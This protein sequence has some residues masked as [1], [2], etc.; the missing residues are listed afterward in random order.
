MMRLL[1][2]LF[3]VEKCGRCCCNSCWLF[4][5]YKKQ[6]N[7]KLRLWFTRKIAVFGCHVQSS[8]SCSLRGFEMLAGR[9]RE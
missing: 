2:Q 7:S 6:R 1:S 9:E 3:A 4:T 8:S 5:M